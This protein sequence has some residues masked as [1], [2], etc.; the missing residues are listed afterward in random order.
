MGSTR[1]AAVG[2]AATRSRGTRRSIVGGALGVLLLVSAACSS[3]GTSSSSTAG[4]ST[5]TQAT[6]G[7]AMVALATRSSLGTVLVDHSGATLYRF[8][9]DGTGKSTCTGSC[10]STWPPVTVPAGT[11]QVVAGT[12]IST[13]EL[14][15]ITRSD[16]SLQVTF[17]GMPLYRY[18]GD[19]KAGDATGQGLNG[20]W[21]V[22]PVTKSATSVTTTTAKRAG[23]YGY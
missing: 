16:G 10:A 14:G 12:G 3:G 2:S 21:F 8:M 23:G 17:K 1:T 19:T 11:T 4:G 20:I 6:T 9:P 5:S 13:G 15:T 18:S 22:V 7:A